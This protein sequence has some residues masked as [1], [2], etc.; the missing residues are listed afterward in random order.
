MSNPTNHCT[1]TTQARILGHA[2]WALQHDVDKHSV[3][4]LQNTASYHYGSTM[5]GSSSR[6]LGHCEEPCYRAVV[7]PNINACITPAASAV[8]VV[9]GRT[10]AWLQYASRTA[11][12]A[13]GNLQVL[14][15]PNRCLGVTLCPRARVHSRALGQFHHAVAILT[16][17]NC[18][19]EIVEPLAHASVQPEAVVATHGTVQVRACNV[20]HLVQRDTGTWVR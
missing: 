17:P 19:V 12:T 13:V 5:G 9:P 14:I 16:K 2:T 4:T 8:E 7:T 18:R 10:H 11:C 15:R 1:T 3:P 6:A 20:A